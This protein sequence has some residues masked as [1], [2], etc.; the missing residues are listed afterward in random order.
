[1]SHR[2][3]TCRTGLAALRSTRPR[4]TA[5][6]RKRNLSLGYDNTGVKERRTSLERREQVGQDVAL[7]GLGNVA[8]ETGLLGS[9]AILVLSPA[10]QRDEHDVAAAG[11]FSDAS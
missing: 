10:G 6:A 3:M 1:M 8:V 2:W 7:D 11:E 5:R 9:P 4:C